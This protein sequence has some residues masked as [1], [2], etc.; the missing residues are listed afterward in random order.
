M[1][2][3]FGTKPRR[4]GLRLVTDK[5]RACPWQFFD[6]VR[7]RFPNRLVAGDVLITRVM[8]SG[9]PRDVGDALAG[10]PVNRAVT[11]ALASIPADAEIESLP[12]DD[13][14]WPAVRRLFDAMVRT[15]GI[16]V[17]TASKILCR[18]RRAL[19]PM[20]DSYVQSFLWD[21]ARQLSKSGN[22]PV[23][24]KSIWSTWASGRGNDVVA[25]MRMIR[26]D[27]R[28]SLRELRAIR[29]A[30]ARDPTAGVPKDAP[31]LRIYEAALFWWLAVDHAR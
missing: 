24:F 12:D 1:L 29:W 5:F 17:S 11:A 30:V 19:I 9:I 22:V 15:R 31:L 7:D 28:C 6:G 10:P 14:T 23:W 2:T 8:E 20:L 21:R 25:Y 16:E 26:H 13:P 18:K 3:F 27:M 4:S